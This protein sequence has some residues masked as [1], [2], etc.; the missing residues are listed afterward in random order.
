MDVSSGAIFLSKKRRIGG[1]CQ[2][3]A[4][5]PKTKKPRHKGTQNV[6]TLGVSVPLIM[7]TEGLHR[8]EMA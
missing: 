1:R 3:R 2:L 7:I 6:N 8:F 5:L 4:N